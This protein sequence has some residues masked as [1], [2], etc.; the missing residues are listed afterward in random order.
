MIIGS[1]R[2]ILILNSSA[3]ACTTRA[4]L[5]LNPLGSQLLSAQLYVRVGEP[6]PSCADSLVP[7]GLDLFSNIGIHVSC[8]VTASFCWNYFLIYIFLLLPYKAWP[9]KY[10]GWLAFLQI[11]Y[12]DLSERVYVLL[13]QSYPSG[14]SSSSS[15]VL[16]FCYLQGVLLLQ[17]IHNRSCMVFHKWPTL[18]RD[19]FCVW[20]WPSFTVLG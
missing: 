1:H 13:L 12:D 7:N 9:V 11:R 17:C 16:W 5:K 19:P 4:S 15:C 10:W 3:D 2:W 20:P 6:H 14:V 8:I 18:R